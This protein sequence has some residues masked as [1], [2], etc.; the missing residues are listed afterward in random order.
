MRKALGVVAL[1]AFAEVGFEDA[2]DTS[3]KVAA[4]LEKDGID[5]INTGLLMHDFDS[6]EQAAK[7]MLDDDIAVILVNVGTWC[8]DNYILQFLKA[9]Q[10]PVILHSFPHMQS[11]SL[12]GVMQ[13]ASVFNDIEFTAYRTVYADPGSEDSV[14]AVKKAFEELKNSENLGKREDTFYIASIGGRSPG[15]TEIAFDEFSLF[16]RTGA[17]VAII[18]ET[19][20]INLADSFTDEDVDKVRPLIEGRGFR[21]SVDDEAIKES[22]RY[23]LA[24]KALVK[25][26]GLKAFAI[27]CYTSLMG[28]VCLGYSLLSDEGIACACEGDVNSAAMMKIMMDVSGQCVNN[29]DI[30]N[31][32]PDDNAI[33]FAHCGSSGFSIAPTPDEVELRPVRIMETGICSMFRPK[34]GTVTAADLVGHGDQL[35]MSI[36]VGEAIEKEYLFPGNQACIKFERNVIDICNDVMSKACG[37]HWM[38]AYG[39]LTEE[40]KKYCEDHDIIFQNLT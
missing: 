18:D 4:S 5:V 35:R 31:P 17:I 13:I 20:L 33:I 10:K 12:C 30:L 37:H 36:M 32:L 11:G 34:L 24:M 29:T 23:Y 6:A 25:K 22:L 39:D 28:K 3:N 40:L 21:I 16:K 9:S 2:L 27:K 26:Y 15:M 7:A 1:A 19:E 8:E 38:V 14:D